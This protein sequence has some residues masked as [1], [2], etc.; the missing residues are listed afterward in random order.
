MQLTA[1]VHYSGVGFEITGASSIL[2]VSD[3]N[4]FQGNRVSSRSF[5]NRAHHRSSNNRVGKYNNISCFYD[6]SNFHVNMDGKVYLEGFVD[7][8]YNNARCSAHFK[9]AALY[10]GDEFFVFDG[11][12]KKFIHEDV[13][14]DYKYFKISAGKRI[15]VF[16]DGDD[17]YFYCN[18]SWKSLTHVDDNESSHGFV[19]KNN[20]SVRMVVG[21]DTYTVSSS[22]NI[23]DL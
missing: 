8:G 15:A 1:C 22:C 21:S 11:Y 7:S 18:G 14:D 5:N 2:R 12:R 10:D 3:L 6:G 19:D 4:Y 20:N 9:M 16:Y 17:L 13:D 23:I